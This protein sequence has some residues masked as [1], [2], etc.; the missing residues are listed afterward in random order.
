[1]LESDEE[2]AENAKRIKL[3][4]DAIEKAGFVD[5]YVCGISIDGRRMEAFSIGESKESFGFANAERW[6]RMVGAMHRR[7]VRWEIESGQTEDD[8]EA[9]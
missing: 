3:V 6:D 2:Q 7:I 1:M 5:Y 4:R 8:L 9:E